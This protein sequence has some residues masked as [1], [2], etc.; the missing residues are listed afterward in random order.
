MTTN[1]QPPP[2]IPSALRR[3]T[4]GAWAALGLA[5]AVLVATYETLPAQV[6]LLRGPTG[7]WIAWAPKSLLVVLR[8]PLM[9][10]AQLGAATIMLHAAVKQGALQWSRVFSILTIVAGIK[11]VAETLQFATLG[12]GLPR[13][14]EQMFYGAALVPVIVGVAWLVRFAWQSRGQFERLTLDRGERLLLGACLAV[15]SCGAAVL[16]QHGMATQP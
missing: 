2:S 5:A 11:S 15:W 6:P 1:A 14:S 16:L 9:G 4:L 7:S 8:I 10:A 12:G 13:T 3:N